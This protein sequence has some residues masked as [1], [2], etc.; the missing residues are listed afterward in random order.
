MIE[1]P[2]PLSDWRMVKL[3][4]CHTTYQ[5]PKVISMWIQTG[6]NHAAKPVTLLCIPEDCSVINGILCST[7]DL[8][9]SCRHGSSCTTF[10]W[11]RLRR[12]MLVM[13]RLLEGEV[14]IWHLP[15]LLPHLSIYTLLNLRIRYF[16]A[17]GLF[18]ITLSSIINLIT[19]KS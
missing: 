2:K 17:I 14:K 6:L 12:S 5:P 10:L 9:T 13:L 3:E 15:Y 8:T 7:C 11:A 4:Q 16:T 1:P 18:S 19:S